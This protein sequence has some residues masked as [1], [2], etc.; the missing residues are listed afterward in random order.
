MTRIPCSPTLVRIIGSLVAVASIACSAPKPAL[1]QNIV[2]GETPPPDSVDAVLIFVGDAGE[3]IEEGSPLLSRMQQDIEMW[4]ERLSRDSAVT[5]L[6][7]GDNVYPSGVHDRTDPSYPRDSAIL[8]AQ[9]K[10]LDGPRARARGSIGYFL[11]GNHDWGNKTGSAGLQRLKNMEAEIL[12]ARKQGIPVQLAP[13]AG[14]PGPSV[15]DIRENMRL[16][17]I[18]THLY[19]QEKSV[20]QRYAFINGMEKAMKEAGDRHVLIAAHH[21][22]TSAGPHGEIATPISKYMG[23]IFLLQ[24][25]GTLVQDLN[26]PIYTDLLSNLRQVFERTRPPLAFIGGHDHSLQVHVGKSVTDPWYILVSG[27]GSKS[28]DLVGADSMRFGTSRPG[29]MTMVFRKQGAV[30]LFLIAGRETKT[31]DECPTPVN[32]DVQQNA[33][34]MATEKLAYSVVYSE[35][36]AFRQPPKVDSLASADTSKQPR[37]VGGPK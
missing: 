13:A 4:S 19:L 15:R 35:R 36:L 17:M 16:M 14:S 18:D 6:F 37:K 5:V 8:W 24:K 32:G 21:P 10:L 11:A 7:L 26:S 9:I 30:D 27:A 33:E 28:T 22:Y 12:T 25:S 20:A 31:A 3:A 23:V 29:F 2:P 34:C 1:F